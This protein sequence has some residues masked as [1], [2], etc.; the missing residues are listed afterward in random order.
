MQS[1][2]TAAGRK[3]ATR[4]LFDDRFFSNMISDCQD[5]KKERRLRCDDGTPPVH[6]KSTTRQAE[7]IKV[8]SRFGAFNC[9]VEQAMACKTECLRSIP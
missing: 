5:S 4:N 2:S 1:A 9:Y 8:M 7:T 6:D 3:N